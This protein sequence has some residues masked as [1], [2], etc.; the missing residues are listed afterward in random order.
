M[1]NPTTP[2][3]V[4]YIRV[5]RI[6]QRDTTSASYQTEIEQSE[7]CE[8]YARARGY[9]VV[10][11]ISDVD[12]SGGKWDRTGL[13]AVLDLAADGA[14]DAV[15]VYRLSRLGRGL[16]GVLKT[17][18]QLQQQQ[19]GL[20]SVSEGIDLTNAAG[21]MLFNVL[22]SFDQY[23]REIRAEYWE[24]TR[25]RARARGVLV[26]PTPYGY[27]R[28][29][30][31]AD[32]GKLYP[33]PVRGPIVAELYSR[34]A[35]RETHADL[36][37]W[38]DKRDPQEPGKQW[39][40]AHVA[41]LLKHRVYLGEVNQAGDRIEGA[42]PALVDVDVWH[43]A[44]GIN[45]RP[46]AALGSAY[47]FKLSGLIRCAGCG[48]VMSGNSRV[49]SGSKPVYSCQRHS[50]RG[51]C[52]Q[53][54]SIL[55]ERAE[56]YV[57]DE[58]MIRL[59]R[60]RFTHRPVSPGADLA[61]MDAAVEEAAERHRSLSTSPRMRA[62]MGDEL[63]EDAVVEQGAEVQRLRDAALA[64]RKA[65]QMD[66]LAD[67]DPAEIE[68]TPPLLRAALESYVVDLR[69]SRGRGMLPQD[70]IAIGFD[71]VLNIEDPV[72]VLPPESSQ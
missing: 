28:H 43:G 29:K 66:D 39:H 6:G 35:K 5:S 21:R 69:V 11:T 30:G 4:I 65:L 50:S 23:E 64:A 25:S 60:R 48:M 58:L 13:N 9:R 42:H 54:A 53:P 24:D 67:Y 57:I 51:D 70:R 49:A 3:A 62:A 41:R 40:R 27:L 45:P 18:E 31:G 47:Q 71:D 68:R 20:M 17:V 38:L 1:E 59:H 33:C 12:V 26:G 55:A 2:R 14:I 8:A 46:A 16:T 34:R 22:A 32:S 72:R 10:D 61:A 37:R 56:R 63:W 36:A 44:Q 15:I 19:V 52:T 7:R